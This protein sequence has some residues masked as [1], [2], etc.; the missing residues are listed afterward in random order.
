MRDIK[1][2][3]AL[4]LHGKFDRW[5][6][7]GFNKTGFT[8]PSLSG[9]IAPDEARDASEQYTGEVDKNG[10]EVYVGDILKC[11]LD[12]ENLRDI[13]YAGLSKSEQE[14]GIHIFA[15]HDIFHLVTYGLW[16]DSFEVIGNIHQHPELLNQKRDYARDQV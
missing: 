13:E 4:Y 5:H 7:W 16:F 12:L 3:Q 8:G 14:T 1:F 9:L 15:V 10:V 6:Y 11:Y 2:R